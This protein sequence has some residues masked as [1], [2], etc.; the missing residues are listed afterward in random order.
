MKQILVSG[1]SA[2]DIHIRSNIDIASVFAD[3]SGENIHL[4]TTSDMLEKYNGGTWSNIAYNLWLLWEHC[5]LLSAAG[6]DF[7][8]ILM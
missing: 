5:I 6:K 3:S 4:S 7:L 2:Y 1:S 8:Y